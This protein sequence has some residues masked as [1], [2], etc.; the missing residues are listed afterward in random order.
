MVSI[1]FAL[2]RI[3]LIS[4]WLS[5][6]SDVAEIHKI[7]TQSSCLRRL[8]VESHHLTSQMRC[9]C[10]VG[11]LILQEMC[12]S[13]L[14][15]SPVMFCESAGVTVWRRELRGL[16]ASL[17]AAFSLTSVVGSGGRGVEET[18]APRASIRLS[19]SPCRSVPGA[20]LRSNGVLLKM[21]WTRRLQSPRAF[22]LFRSAWLSH[23]SPL[24]FEPLPDGS[25]QKT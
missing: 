23:R 20:D 21:S 12:Q 9:A 7:N 13:F 14:A 8:I 19:C 16:C 10:F 11:K 15:P 17:P 22:L 25:L 4:V 2:M 3:L 5:A 1:A 6:T 24:P 18:A